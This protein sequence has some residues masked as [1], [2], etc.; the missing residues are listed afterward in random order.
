MACT[1]SYMWR[2]KDDEKIILAYPA[3]RAGTGYVALTIQLEFGARA[4][5][6]PYQIHPVTCDMAAVIDGIQFP[7]ARPLVT[8]AK[9]TFWEKATAAHVCCLQGRLRGER[10]CR[11]WYDLAALSNTRHYPLAA[12]DWQLAHQVAEQ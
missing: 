9:R 10:Y 8:A 12:R 1:P 3:L 5:G 2:V 6:K 11:H 7:A 4:T